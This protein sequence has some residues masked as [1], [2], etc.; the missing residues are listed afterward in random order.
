MAPIFKI[1]RFICSVCKKSF[2]S[3]N[4]LKNHYEIHRKRPLSP[5][6]PSTI[7]QLLERSE[8]NK[9]ERFENAPITKQQERFENAPITKQQERFEN[10]PNINQQERFENNQKERVEEN[11]SNNQEGGAIQMEKY[12]QVHNG[13]NTQ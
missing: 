12:L 7:L 6:P 10:A 2:I 13:A 4:E 1:E 8:N 9:Q 11:A 5:N 3:K